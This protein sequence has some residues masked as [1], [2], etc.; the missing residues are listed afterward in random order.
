MK[1]V[2]FASAILL[3]LSSTG[4]WAARTDELTLTIDQRAGPQRRFIPVAVIGAGVDGHSRGDSAAIYRPATLQAM[5]AAG[6]GPLSYRLRTELGIHA[7][8][9]NPRGQWSDAQNHQGYWTSDDQLGA[10]ILASYGY[11]LPRRGNT[12]DQAEDNGYSRLAD[13]DLASFWKSN[14]YLDRRYTGEDNRRHPQWLIADLGQRQPVNAIRLVWGQPYATHYTVQYW[15]GEDPDDPDEYPEGR[16]HNFPQGV[17]TT[18]QGGDAP[19]RLSAKPHAVRFLRVLLHE[20]SGQAP[21]NANDPRD[22]LGYAVREVFIGTLD[23]AGSFHDVVRHGPQRDRQTRFFVSSTD[24]WHR[25]GDL[26][27]DVEQPGVDRVLTSPLTR[28]L[29][30]LMAVGAL[31]DTPENAAALLRYLQRRGYPLRGIEIGEEPD[32]QYA[33]PED[34]GALYLQVADALRAVD[35]KLLLGGPSFQSLSDEAMM[36]WSGTEVAPDQPWLARFIGYLQR[37]QRLV[38]LGF[39]SF[40]WYPFDAVCEPPAAQ[41]QQAA[42]LL[43]TGI[44]ELHR[45]GLPRSTPLYLTEYGYS[46]LSGQVTVDLPGALFNADTL[47]T[48]LSLGGAAAYL[49]GYEP[50]PIYAGPPECK[51]WGNNTLFLS[52]EDRRIQ[53]NTAT[54]HSATLL[55]QHWL[56]NPAEPHTLYPVRWKPSSAAGSAPPAL[57]AYAV[58]RPDQQWALLLLNLDS[59]QAWS[60]AADWAGPAAQATPLVGPADLYQFSAVQYHWQ[61]A[62]EQGRPSRSLPPAHTRLPAGPITLHLPPWSLTV[63]RV[64][65][66]G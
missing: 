14:P 4:G 63:L 45:Q 2:A 33:A 62:G 43:T 46:A 32:G 20:T 50:S 22:A 9:W 38:D 8:H 19:L 42:K 66:P 61:A 59:R 3:A 57:R 37:R 10:P 54:Y 47:G 53:A 39:L 21:P 51:T 35:P 31:Y 55:T 26:D 41:L 56:G 64:S 30:T 24:P 58:R 15:A 13:G 27:H 40:E 5:L 60:V 44:A 7:W 65:D 12:I 25:A 52:G 49:Y 16:W 29:P 1:F 28:G 23:A 48:F 11:R 6:L 18:G 17:V 34:Y 36:A